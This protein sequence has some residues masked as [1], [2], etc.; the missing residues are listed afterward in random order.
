MSDLETVFHKHG[1]YMVHVHEKSLNKTGKH[2]PYMVHVEGCGGLA[3][4]RKIPIQRGQAS[5]QGKCFGIN[6]NS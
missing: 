1:P 2:G 4:I 3:L 5:K 6:E